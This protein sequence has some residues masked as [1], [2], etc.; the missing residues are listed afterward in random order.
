MWLE[1]L[2][3]GEEMTLKGFDLLGYFFPAWIKCFIIIKK[4]TGTG[5]GVSSALGFE[6]K[7]V[8]KDKEVP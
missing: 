2:L 5:A 8:G 3:S 7:G 1:H 4:K 6:R